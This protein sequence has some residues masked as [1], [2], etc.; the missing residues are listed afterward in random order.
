MCCSSNVTAWSEQGEV[1][2]LARRG[3]SESA[4]F[5]RIFDGLKEAIALLDQQ[6]QQLCRSGEQ[7]DL[8]RRIMTIPG[9]GR[10]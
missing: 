5:G 1:E 9:L 2:S 8:Y 6:I 3:A 7:R 4:I 10:R